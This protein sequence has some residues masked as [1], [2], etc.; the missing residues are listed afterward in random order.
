MWFFKEVVSDKSAVLEEDE[1]GLRDS[2]KKRDNLVML[3]VYVA[4]DKTTLME[5]TFS[6]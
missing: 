4:G 2:I 1:R 3:K 5:P 6:K